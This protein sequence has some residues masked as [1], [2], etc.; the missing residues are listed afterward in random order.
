MLGKLSEC[1]LVHW[2][3]PDRSPYGAQALGYRLGWSKSKTSAVLVAVNS[4]R[5]T[6]EAASNREDDAT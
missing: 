3:D 2:R 1:A 5:K 6:G 4:R